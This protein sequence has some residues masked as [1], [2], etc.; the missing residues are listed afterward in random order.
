MNKKLVLI[1][2]SI[3]LLT[4]CF[5]S[6]KP[7]KAWGPI[8]HTV[9]C[10]E[11]IQS[12]GSTTITNLITTPKNEPY[13][14]CGLM[15]PD[16]T[17]LYYYTNFKKYEFTHTW[18][19]YK[20]LWNDAVTKGS[21]EAKAFA[22]GVG[23]HLLQDYI[24]HN[25]YIPKQI[26]EKWMPNNLIHP[27]MEFMVETK[28]V[29]RNEAIIIERAKN[30]FTFWNHIFDDSTMVYPIGHSL[31]GQP[32][33]VIGWA[34]LIA[35]G[36]SEN[37]ESYANTFNGILTGGDFYGQG[38]YTPTGAST[39]W[40]IYQAVANSFKNFISTVDYETYKV[41]TIN[42]TVQW[43]QSTEISSPDK[44]VGGDPKTSSTGIDIL[45]AMDQTVYIKFTVVLAGLGL[46]VLYV[47]YRRKSGKR[48]I[49]YKGLS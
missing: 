12:A 34:S 22:I 39:F 24:A 36:E 43:W 7:V 32:M 45:G 11:A 38:G 28:E 4:V 26:T 9:F 16:I 40:G 31:A 33:S 23:T 8:S 18:L 14:M 10:N 2:F 48:I 35:V 37:W 20:Q 25:F 19:F 47:Y 17:V 1:S 41:M 29:G 13:F 42:S 5:S 46:I 44:Y 49:P 15:F 6:I 30:S 3:L 27:F 21:D